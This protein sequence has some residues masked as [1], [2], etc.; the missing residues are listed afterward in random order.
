MATPKE[1]DRLIPPFVPGGDKSFQDYLKRFVIE[2]AL[3][4]IT[5]SKD[6]RKLFLQHQNLTL[7]EVMEKVCSPKSILETEY[8]VLVS[9]LTRYFQGSQPKKIVAKFE[10]FQ[11]VQG[12]DES[13]AVYV[14]EVS[15]LAT[16]CGFT[17]RDENLVARLV[18]GLRNE[19]LKEAFLQVDDDKLTLDYVTT[20]IYAH[21]SAEKSAKSIQGLSTEVHKVS[22]N[23]KK[24]FEKKGQQQQQQT[25]N[26]G[27]PQTM[28]SGIACQSCGNKNHP[29]S[30][31]YFREAECN[32]CKK[33][34]H[35]AKV[36]RSGLTPQQKTH[37]VEGGEGKWSKNVDVL[38]LEAVTDYILQVEVV[39]SRV[40]S[41]KKIELQIP[42]S[43]STLSM[44]VDTGATFSLIGWTA[45]LR[46]FP[47]TTVLQPS[48]VK[49]RVWGQNG[50]IRAAGKVPVQVTPVNKEPVLLE[51]LVMEDD[52]PALLGRN[53]FEPLGI[54]VGLP[55]L[56]K[57]APSEHQ[58][59]ENKP[60]IFKLTEVPAVFEDLSEVFAPELGRFRGA[61]VHIPLKKDARPIQLPARQVPF[62]LVNKAT[63]AIEKL[64]EMGVLEKVMFSEWATP[65]VYV[66]KGDK[67]RLCADFSATVN[68]QCEPAAYP[69][70]TID[71]LLSQIKPGGVFSKIDLAEAYLQFEV[72]EE[73]SKVLTISTHKGLFKFTRLP[74]GLSVCPS[75][76]QNKVAN[77]LA[78]V[79][80]VYVYFDDVLMRADN[81]EKMKETARRVLTILQKNGLKVKISKCEFFVTELEYL[82]YQ[83]TANGVKPTAEKLEALN[84]LVDPESKEELQALLGYYN[85]YDRFIPNKAKI[86]TPVYRLLQKG[87]VFKWTPECKEAIASINKILRETFEL[88]YYDPEK[89]LRLACDGSFKGIGAVLSH[90]DAKGAEIEVEA[91]SIVWAVKK[92]KKYLWGRIFELLTDHKPLLRIFG[93]GKPMSEDLPS[94]FKRLPLPCEEEEEEDEEE[95]AKVA[96]LQAVQGDE[97]IS[98]DD[99]ARETKLDEQLQEVLQHLM[100]GRRPDSLTAGLEEFAK[101]WLNLK[102]TNGVIVFLGRA[103][104]PRVQRQKVLNLLHANHFGQVKMKN[105]ARSYFWWPQMDQDIE[106][107]CQSCQPCALF[108]KSPNRAPIIPWSVPHRPWGRVHLDF[109]EMSRGKIFIV[110]ADGLSGWIDAEQTKA[111]DTTTVISYCRKLFRFQGLPDII[112]AD[113]GP[114]FRSNEFKQFC[115]RN[116]VELIFSP[117]YSPQTNG[118]AE[119]AVQTVKT[120]LKKVPEAEWNERLDSFLLGHNA[121]PKSGTGV[122]PAE[123]NLGRKPQTLLDKVQL[124][125]VV[126]K[127]VAGRERKAAEAVQKLPAVPVAGQSA[128]LRSYR[129]PKHRWEPGEVV[130]VLGPRRVQLQT[131]HGVVDRH[132]DQVK[133]TPRVA[134]PTGPTAAAVDRGPAVEVEIPE[135]DF[136]LPPELFGP[137]GPPTGLSQAAKPVSSTPAAKAA[138]RQPS[139]PVD[140]GRPVR[141]R[142][143]PDYYKVFDM[144][145]KK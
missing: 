65:V 50:E 67:V 61:P 119:R 94:K 12:A 92:L 100:Q 7:F 87:V 112:V 125:M 79:P 129:D 114:A 64:E 72:D 11:R 111:M 21:E 57:S 17:D 96:F 113:N 103:V 106:R 39:Q 108:N 20:K 127:K 58:G 34:G 122:A 63:E 121:A 62:G 49:M 69:L 26:A 14:A 143:P 81:K 74:P 126:T 60:E 13:V 36:C 75:V 28:K 128:V 22:F 3:Q 73:S 4:E 43:D 99:V 83:F 133:L 78:E 5:E 59:E 110:A 130:N 145:K 77:L 8:D 68:P 33:K 19:K 30:Q 142:R 51:L 10:F 52:G 107:V 35:I 102:V 138:S 42:L 38:K 54:S 44:E 91:L 105:L 132:V 66:E 32:K 53:W 141:E 6:K 47:D 115:E 144:G 31:C 37:F 9:K 86:L 24:Q 123:F 76:F 2:F 89:P 109:M 95:Q 48:D 56:E 45:F 104:I 55:R 131:Q 1:A 120:F 139:A 25:S 137:S 97:M 41:N 15:S 18:T 90:V 29:R 134:P 140:S 116:R 101:R 88:A 71:G 124:D 93:K 85:Y 70:P 82:G 80:G 117:P 23:K 135:V 118:L 40:A 84:K 98:L 46:H 136:E 16:K 27:T